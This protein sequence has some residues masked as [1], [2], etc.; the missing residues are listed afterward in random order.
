MTTIVWC[1]I[2]VFVTLVMLLVYAVV[3]HYSPQRGDSYFTSSREV[4]GMRW[5]KYIRAIRAAHS[6]YRK[7]VL[8][9]NDRLRA[10][11]EAEALSHRGE[12]TVWGEEAY[13]RHEDGIET[14]QN[15]FKGVQDAALLEY[16]KDTK[17]LHL[18]YV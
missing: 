18:W 15:N 9:V 8:S 12:V 7:N 6:E 3:W 17:K 13:A 2:G 1:L 10:D 14:V 16:F 4:E 11:G 5:M